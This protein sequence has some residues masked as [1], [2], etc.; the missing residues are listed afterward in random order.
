ML[1]LHSL[2]DDEG[3]VGERELGYRLEHFRGGSIGANYKR[4]KKDGENQSTAMPC[5]RL[6]HMQQ[7]APF[8]WDDGT[9]RSL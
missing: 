2:A 6:G 9:Q 5:A 1:G 4:R 7:I 8:C 3:A